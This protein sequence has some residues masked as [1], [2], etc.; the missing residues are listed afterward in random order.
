M[1]SSAISLW[2]SVSNEFAAAADTVG[3]AVAAVHG[4]HRFAASGIQWRKGVVV[5][6][7]HAVRRA[8]Q[9]RVNFGSDKSF[10]AAVAGRD[11]STDLA[12]LRLPESAT[13]PVAPVDPA[14][15][16]KLAQLVLALARSRR[17][18]VV[19]SAGIIGGL[20]GE[21][22]TWRGGRLDQ[23]V[24]LALEL[25]PGFSG[26]PLLSA[27]GKVI[28]INTTAIARGRAVMIP[29]S[30]VNRVVDELLEKGH[31]ARP[32]LGLAMQPVDVPE[33]LAAKL[34]TPA[35]RGLLVVQVEQGG[36]AEKA[37]ILIGDIL[38][39]LHEQSLQETENLH[40][41]LLSARIGT[42]L[43]LTLLRAGN[44]VQISITLGERP[45]R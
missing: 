41:A 43:P 5:T 21:F 45:E 25:Y 30:T 39:A 32:Y 27:Q 11:P 1:A 12:V 19:A 33:A 35:S 28:G 20:S 23:Q 34:K 9:V 6:A 31:I 14:A 29:V 22:H 37:G 17:G 16:L 18:N 40:D 38:V 4:Q 3:K 24:R 13:L 7:E 26:G 8:E 36:P 42:A 44:P 10:T 15:E 2:E